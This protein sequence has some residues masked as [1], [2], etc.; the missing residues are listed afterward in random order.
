MFDLF[1]FSCWCSGHS[2]LSNSYVGGLGF[3]N[4]FDIV[5]TFIFILNIIT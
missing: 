5:L 3:P 2:H 4:R 1:V